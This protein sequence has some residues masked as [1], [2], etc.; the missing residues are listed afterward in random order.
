MTLLVQGDWKVVHDCHVNERRG[1]VDHLEDGIEIHLATHR[2]EL[3][4]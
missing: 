4:G 1:L 3:F 2:A